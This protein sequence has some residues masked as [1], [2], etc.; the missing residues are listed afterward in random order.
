PTPQQIKMATHLASEGVDIIFGSHSHVVQPVSWV[1]SPDGARRTLV[2]WSLGNFIS[3]QRFEFLQRHNTEDGLMVSVR[4]ERVAS[5]SSVQ[6]TGIDYQPLWVHRHQKNGRWH[7]HVLPLLSALRNLDGY[8]LE[9][10]TNLTRA[11]NSLKRTMKTLAKAPEWS[12]PTWTENISDQAVT[13]KPEKLV[14]DS[15]PAPQKTE[16]DDEGSE[17]EKDE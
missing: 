10:N 17:D 5:S 16:S 9:Q 6:I 2:V 15:S 13:V 7:Y 3:N 8:G 1:E 4:V 12:P 11:R 14:T